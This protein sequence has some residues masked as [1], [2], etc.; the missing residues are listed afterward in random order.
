MKQKKHRYIFSKTVLALTMVFF[1]LPIIY[2]V[3]FSFNDSKSLSK[4]SG[5]SLRWNEKMLTT[6]I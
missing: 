4:F 1:Y 5:F 3:I 6:R 2:T